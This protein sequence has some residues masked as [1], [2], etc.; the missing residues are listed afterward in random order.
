MVIVLVMLILSFFV[1][2]VGIFNYYFKMID[3]FKVIFSGFNDLM[4]Y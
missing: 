2:I 1:I 4:I 3:G